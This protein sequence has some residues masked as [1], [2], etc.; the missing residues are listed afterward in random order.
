MNGEREVRIEVGDPRPDHSAHDW[1]CTYRIDGSRE[2]TVRGPDRLA[3]VYVALLAAENTAAR[4]VPGVRRLRHAARAVVA[5]AREFGAPLGAR[6]VHT[7]A[8]PVV[9]TIGRPRQDPNRP[10]TYLC[11]FRIDDRTEA[12]GQG[13]DE[14][15]AVMSAIRSVGA[16][17]GYRATGLHPRKTLCQKGFLDQ[18]DEPLVCRWSCAPGSSSCPQASDWVSQNR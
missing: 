6:A 2:H 11:P 14:I 17:V 3:A 10:H 12:F 7:S 18:L 16:I 4:A 5:D 9:I 13:F 8:G 15:R 1:L